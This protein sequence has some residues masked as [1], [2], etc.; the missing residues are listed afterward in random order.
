MLNRT[1]QLAKDRA[2]QRRTNAVRQWQIVSLI[3]WCLFIVL[4]FTSSSHGVWRSDEA[5]KLA[6]LHAVTKVYVDKKGEW[7]SYDN[8][9]RV[10]VRHW[11]NE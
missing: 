8:G 10:E 6:P 3:G 11:T 4:S 2:D 1:A 9:E 7:R 5:P